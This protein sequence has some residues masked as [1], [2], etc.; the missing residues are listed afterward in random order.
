LEMQNNEL[1]QAQ[2]QLI[3]A[4][5]RYLDLYDYAPVGYLTL[6]TDLTIQQANLT[7]ASM[8]G[9][10]RHDLVNQP[11]AHFIAIEGQDAY[12]LLRVRLTENDAPQML[13]LPMLKTDG[14]IFWARF[15]IIVAQETGYK[16]EQTKSIY[17]LTMADI[18]ARKHAQAESAHRTAELTATMASLADG[19]VVFDPAGNIIWINDSAA[20]LLEYNL[21]DQVQPFNEYL[22]SLN[23]KT[24]DG[25]AYPAGM[26][27][28]ETALRGTTTRGA[29]MLF[30]HPD[31]T[32]WVLV[33]AA[34]ISMLGKQQ[35]G[36]VVTF[37]DIT[38]V[39]D[40]QEQQ[41][42]LHLVSHDLG[43]PLTV[44]KGHA[45]L[46]EGM[47]DDPSR[48]EIIRESLETIQRNVRRMTVM[49]RDLT[50][51]ARFDGGQLKLNLKPV[52]MVSYLRD[53]LP[54]TLLEDDAARIVLESK[55]NTPPVMADQDRMDRIVS[56][57]LSNALKY[58]EPGS[59]IIIDVRQQHNE[60]VVS[61]T[62][63]GRGIS[64]EDIPYL[65][66]RF[67]RS[68]DERRAEG[69]G[70]GLYITK[71]LVDAHGGRIWVESEVGKGSTF[72]FALPVV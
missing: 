30:H 15:D 63:N 55:A 32:M 37:S 8:L 58:S 29:L 2:E 9:I 22:R 54:R 6:S 47:L 18:N 28:T 72:S 57:L 3:T 21:A 60:V 56:N 1:R 12:H 59:R 65:F 68:R 71:Q 23:I 35:I 53:Y 49:I 48:N 51:M 17:R 34:P 61:V 26:M 67:Y 14:K 4:R 50:E 16:D 52:E 45:Q 10:A 38:P 20:Q 31:N 66:Q 70:L 25:S 11:L 41:I 69:I 13:E 24:A 40:L 43:T 46:I 19:L 44:I 27:P 5:D 33:S 42:L 36:V 62:D 39:H 64:A 7:S